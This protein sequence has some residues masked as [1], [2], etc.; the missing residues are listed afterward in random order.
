MK[1]HNPGRRLCQLLICFL[2]FI[3]GAGIGYGVAAGLMQTQPGALCTIPFVICLLIALVLH[4]CLHTIGHWIFGR[5]TGLQMIA[6]SFLR[7]THVKEGQRFFTRHALPENLLSTCIMVPINGRRKAS[8]TLYWLGGAL[9]NLLTA[10]LALFLLCLGCWSLSSFLGCFAFSLFLAGIWF[11]LF[12]GL[13]LD[14]GKLPSDGL[15]A[16]QMKQYPDRLNA[17]EKNLQILRFLSRGNQNIDHVPKEWLQDTMEEAADP[18]HALLWLRQYELLICSG[19]QL[20]ADL[21]LASLY[22]NIEN[23]PEEWQNRIFQECIFSLAYQN[24]DR[25]LISQMMTPERR[26]QC[27]EAGTPESCRCLYAWSLMTNQDPRLIAKYKSCAFKANSQLAFRPA[28]E[29]WKQ[30]LTLLQ[31]PIEHS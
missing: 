28:A 5:L 23:F 14:H 22:Q 3:L 29:A 10:L 11:S 31:H 20:K 19:Y 21:I 4:S 25:E 27:E 1:S 17:F 6:I 16:I 24:C 9:M 26:R 8:Y 18:F 7:H 15:K 30:M 13:P 12:N 2:Y